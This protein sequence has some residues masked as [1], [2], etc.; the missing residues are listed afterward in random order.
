MEW[1]PGGALPGGGA[2]E[3]RLHGRTR[4]VRVGADGSINDLDR[5]YVPE[6]PDPRTSADFGHPGE[7][8]DDAFWRLV[9][10]FDRAPSPH[11]TPAAGAGKLRAYVAYDPAGLD[12]G[13]VGEL[14]ASQT[15]LI[16]WA[17]ERGLRR[18]GWPGQPGGALVVASVEAD[19]GVVRELLP[20][21]SSVIT[22][23][24]VLAKALRSTPAPPGSSPRSRGK[25]FRPA[26][27]PF[28]TCGW[29]RVERNA[30]G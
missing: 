19:E 29:R 30:S 25:S 23:P 4:R 3:I 26:R 14:V 27:Q 6:V 11:A 28:S 21:A 10:L 15:A 9:D 2:W 17:E 22:P 16:E 18:P 7:L 24:T 12:P 1:R 20:P 8:R 13:A 5:L